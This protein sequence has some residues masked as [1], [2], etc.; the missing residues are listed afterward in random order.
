[1]AVLVWSMTLA[2]A[3]ITIA[4][5]LARRAH[6]LRVLLPGVRRNA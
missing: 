3:S 4:F 2:G 1:M 6:W 5:T